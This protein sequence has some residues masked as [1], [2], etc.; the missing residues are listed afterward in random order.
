[1]IFVDSSAVVAMIAR[2]PEGPVFAGKLES[3][4]EKITAGHVILESCMRL[5]SIFDFSP[6]TADS[7]VSN[8]LRETATE[9]VP[10]TEEIAHIAVAAFERYGK[11]RGTK[12]KLNFGDCLSYACAK[13]HG[14]AL[15][16]KGNDF[17]GTDI[18]RA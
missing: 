15:L 13:A 6:T 12:A 10:I 4:R 14:A 3:A 18:A 5:S 7:L 16:F 11:G 17:A 1:V 2:E 9:V 8:L